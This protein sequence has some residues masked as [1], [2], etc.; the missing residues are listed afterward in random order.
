MDLILMAF[1]IITTILMLPV[2]LV[3]EALDRWT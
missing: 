3:H 2:A 1:C